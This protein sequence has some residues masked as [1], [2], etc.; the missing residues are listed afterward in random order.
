MSKKRTGNPR[1]VFPRTFDK[2]GKPTC[3]VCGGPLT[4]RQRRWCSQA[5]SD[6]V[7]IVTS[8]SFARHRVSLRDKGVC[9]KCG[10]DTQK[11]KRILKLAGID[12]Y[13][14]WKENV[15]RVLMDRE[16]RALKKEI[17]FT[18]L[19]LWEMDHI[20]P[21]V[22]GGGLCGLENLQTLCIP[23]HHEETRE[24]A[25]RR[26]AAKRGTPLFVEASK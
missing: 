6:H 1:D 15:K 5:C 12:R 3:G 11:L 24:L 16:I 7:L 2:D 21:V 26:A 9:A 22:E 14:P 25:A 19:H 23:C 4:G 10:C 18:T 17:G 13:H 20:L 8:P